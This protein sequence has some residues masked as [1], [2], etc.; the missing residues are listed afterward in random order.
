MTGL[1]DPAEIFRQ[2][3]RDLLETLEQTLLDLDQDPGNRDLVD[4]TFRALHTL[5]GSGAMF[6]YGEVADFVHEFET[7]F[8]RVRK[9]QAD[10]NA[11]LVAIALAA[12]DHIADLVQAPG[13]HADA[14]APILVELRRI[15]DTD[16]VAEPEPA[17]RGDVAEAEDGGVVVR[18]W[19]PTDAIAFGT[20]PLLLLDEMRDLG[21]SRITALT[22]RLPALPDLDPAC[23]YLG[24]DVE[25]DAGIARADIDDV[26][27]FVRDGMELCI[28]PLQAE[29]ARETPVTD[30]P[31]PAPRRDLAV[32][33]PRAPEPTATRE[34]KTGA[35]LRVP[36]ERLDELMDRVGEL[37]IAQSRLAQIAGS[38]NDLHLKAVVEELERL[39][40]GLRDTTMG[41]RMV[42]I[43]T[44]F[45]RFRRLVHDLA[46]EL[47]K[48]IDFIT[49]G[50]ETELDKT[51]IERLADPLVHLIRNCIDHGIEM[52]D[53]RADGGKTRTGQIRL[54]AT[55]KGS[56][57]AITISDDGAGLD[58]AR[59]RAKAER[60]GLLDP[61]AKITDHEL[62]QL[63]FHPGFSTAPT[64]TA[65]SGRGV[66]M[67]VVKRGI[68]GL[69]GSID[70]VSTPG[71]G[72][73][74]TLRLPLTLAIIE[75]MLV[76]V[77][78]GRYAIP[79]SAVEECVEL[80]TLCDTHDTGRNFLNIR[81]GLVPFLRLRELFKVT[82]DRP[83]Y[84]KVVIV[85]AGEDRIGLVV[86]QIIGNS[87][88]VIKS[89]SKLHADIETF[90]G[91]TIL[92]DGTVALILD[93][94][95]LVSFGQTFEGRLRDAQLGKVA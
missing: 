50:E 53:A 35:S 93:V 73:T 46:S 13:R 78:D 10:V 51:M 2:E 37:V 3:A 86:D 40:S 17:L 84:P 29:T 12:K 45:S 82:T 15:V 32:N 65:V 67:D 24:W 74:A 80:P 69:R 90:S 11:A 48:D 9:G 41:I 25:F 94:G 77:G 49:A 14:G 22:D 36:A 83:A 59:I 62:Y 60:T 70:L 21:A 92:G 56:E 68:E 64:V 26:F 38:G 44:L 76:Q 19:L 28:E 31:D 91:A 95:A 8:D 6:G 33:T 88:T 79:L 27:M 63:I 75:S 30:D 1:T 4:T 57:V 61:E 7:A 42:P 89:L 81:G 52:P 58:A 66:G 54:S 87:Q 72:T 16:E 43:G 34:Q 39:S 23:S 47:G 85:A 5:K 20:D 18:F 55:H 71:K